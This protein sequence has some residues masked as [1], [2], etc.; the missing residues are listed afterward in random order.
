MYKKIFFDLDGTL[1]DSK[2][3]VTKSV[4]YAL[5]KFGIK[6][7]LDELLGFIGPPLRDSFQKYYGFDKESAEKATDFY[8]ERYSAKGVHELSLFSGISE[9]IT[10][11]HNAGRSLYIATSKGEIH[12]KQIMREAGLD[13]LFFFIGGADK[14]AERLNKADVLRYVCDME[15]IRTFD[16][17]I[18]VGDR[19][20]D[21]HGAHAVGM[22]CAAVLYGFGTKAELEKAG[23]DFIMPD[24]ASLQVWLLA[25]NMPRFH[26]DTG[27]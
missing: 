20:H 18:M 26:G 1:C 17:C 16:D 19:E 15:N 4:Q 13:G 22:R 9:M 11:L 25:G 7:D 12:A 8:R 21:V 14:T 10:K 5:G 6:A 23:A 3:G 2:E 24:V 27:S